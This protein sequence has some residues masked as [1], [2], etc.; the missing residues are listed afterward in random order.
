LTNSG[1]ITG[2]LSFDGTG[3]T[4]TNSHAGTIDGG[5]TLAT[6]SD[7]V[8]NAG[9]I[10]GAIT[11][12]GSGAHS[13]ITNT[14]E[15]TG[16]IKMV[17][18]DTLI[19]HG[20]IYGNVTCGTGDTLSNTGVI[21]GD[22]TLGVSDTFDLSVGEVTG[23]VTAASGGKDLFKFSGNFGNEAINSF[24]AG[25]GSTH[26]TIQF[27]ANDFGSFAAVQKDMTQVGADV[28]IRLDGTDSIT[29]D[30]IKLASLV[31]ADFKFV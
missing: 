22:V 23:A 6:G 20:Q 17:G 8:T 9:S 5:I 21:H 28:V 1:I 14:G 3:D 26:D 19:N 27:A 30:N 10:D 25:T 18:T 7:A 12:T 24:I 11:F 29:L 15:I 13:V 2:A 16:N 31:S 4:I